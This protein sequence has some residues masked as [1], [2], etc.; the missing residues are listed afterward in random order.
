MIE[1]GLASLL[2]SNSTVTAIIADQIS[3][4]VLPESAKYPA[5]TYQVISSIAEYTNDGPAGFARTR[6]E[7][8]AWATT[9]GSSKAVAQAIRAVL[10]GYSGTLP[11]GTHVANAIVVNI[12]DQF[13]S[14]A[15]LYRVQTD[16][17]VW[18]TV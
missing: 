11:D 13:D 6:I 10:D 7:L 2:L 12:S 3:P 16:Y 1:S 14:D 5:V 9:Y 4:L 8:N 17:S 15:R 18:H